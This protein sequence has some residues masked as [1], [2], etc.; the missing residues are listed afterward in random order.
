MGNVVS[1]SWLRIHCK[2]FLAFFRRLCR[3]IRNLYSYFGFPWQ[4]FGIPWKPSGLIYEDMIDF[5]SLCNS[6]SEC[7]WHEWLKLRYVTEKFVSE[8]R[9]ENNQNCAVLSN[10]CEISFVQNPDVSARRLAE[11][12]TVLKA[13]ISPFSMFS[14]CMIKIFFLCMSMNQ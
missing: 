4:L 10:V 2:C 14:S 7:S 5:R 8:T 12:D 13:L 1:R 9:E 6:D 3:N 11:H